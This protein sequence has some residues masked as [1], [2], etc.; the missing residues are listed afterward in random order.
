M[1][2][3][4]WVTSDPATHFTA[5]TADGAIEVESLSMRHSQPTIWGQ[6]SGPNA[7]RQYLIKA[8]TFVTLGTDTATDWRLWFFKRAT[9]AVGSGDVAL[10]EVVGIVEFNV[11]NDARTVAGV[12]NTDYFADHDI[13]LP[14]FDDDIGSGTAPRLHVGLQPV[15][16][17]ADAYADGTAERVVRVALES[18]DYTT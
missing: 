4:I 10:H 12:T 5:A 17:A 6:T 14:Y 18:V 7:R 2:N 3:L 16:D 15:G 13:E 1:K 11:S 9:G 8:V